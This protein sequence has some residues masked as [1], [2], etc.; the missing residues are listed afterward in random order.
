M[1]ETPGGST[2]C[3]VCGVVLDPENVALHLAWHHAEQE[4]LAGLAQTL[5]EMV[6]TVR[7]REG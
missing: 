3:D 2:S 6:E 4:R 7:G 1:T 5:S